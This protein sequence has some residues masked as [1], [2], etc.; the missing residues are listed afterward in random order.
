MLRCTCASLMRP[1]SVSMDCRSHICLRCRA[2][3]LSIGRRDGAGVEFSGVEPLMIGDEIEFARKFTVLRSANRAGQIVCGQTETN[4][5]GYVSAFA[6]STA[7]RVDRYSP[8][9]LSSR[10]FAVCESHA[11]SAFLLHVYNRVQAVRP[12]GGRWRS[13]S[14]QAKAVDIEDQPDCYCAVGRSSAAAT[15]RGQ[16]ERRCMLGPF[17]MM[18]SAVV[19]AARVTATSS[20]R[21]CSCASEWAKTVLSPGPD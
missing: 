6:S 16:W 1:V 9:R 2:L 4:L 5:C 18:L 17:R 7:G 3:R 13:T 21:R 15:S 8:K 19:A 10:H 14:F 11:W 12:V 20:S